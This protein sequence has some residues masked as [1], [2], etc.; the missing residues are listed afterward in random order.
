MYINTSP[1]EAFG[2][3][4]TSKNALVKILISVDLIGTCG[5]EIMSSLFVCLF[6]AVN[7][8]KSSC[9]IASVVY[10]GLN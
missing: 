2:R 3:K 7:L 6:T 9:L 8:F 10:Y 4:R 5:H 1:T